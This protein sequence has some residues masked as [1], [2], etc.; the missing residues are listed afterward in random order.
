MAVAV[1]LAMAEMVPLKRYVSRG[2]RPWLFL[3][4]CIVSAA[5]GGAGSLA[6]HSVG[7]QGTEE[8]ESSCPVTSIQSTI[9]R[10]AVDDWMQSGAERSA[11][12]V[13]SIRSGQA[14]GFKIYAIG[15]RSPLAALGLRNG[16]TIHSIDGMDI[17]SP[18]RALE[19]YALLQDKSD[20]RIML[21]RDGCPVSMSVTL[22]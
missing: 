2:K 15:S 4:A 16:D 6:L 1:S 5:M 17:A 9:L 22:Y 10:S 12:I 19:A 14:N 7:H 18:D 20:F 13:P 11:R 8:Q 3:L 21:T